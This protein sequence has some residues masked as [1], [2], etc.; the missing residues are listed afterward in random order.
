MD[1]LMYLFLYVSVLILYS[2]QY[3]LPWSKALGHC[4]ERLQI[5]LSKE[6][7]V[8][9]FF[10]SSPV[11]FAGLST[12]ELALATT[13]PLALILIV[14]SGLLAFLCLRRKK[15]KKENKR[16]PPISEDLNPVYGLYYFSDGQRVDDSSVEVMDENSY[17]D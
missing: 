1:S 5:L 7:T 16:S 10:Q 13:I 3:F 4:V 12:E 15:K 9:I 6:M 2:L 11:S 17:Y 14:A 8:T